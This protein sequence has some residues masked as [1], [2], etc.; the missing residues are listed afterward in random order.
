ML[1]ALSGHYDEAAEAVLEGMPLARQAGARRYLTAMLYSLAMARLAQGKED[2]AQAHLDEAAALVQQTG[3]SFFGAIVWSGIARAAKGYDQARRAL[4][5]GEAFLREPCLSHCHL[6][7][8]QGAIDVSLD[9]RAWDEALRYAAAL[10]RYVS[11]EP[12]PWATLMIERARALAAVGS[13]NKSAA[14]FADLR[15]IRSEIERAGIRSAL[16][17]V[18]LALAAA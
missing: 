18:E 2:E 16:P 17:N 15:R 10:E 3:N 11:A 5:Q 8:Y 6:N 9:A 1:L 12:L 7:F 13:G 14:L 4:A